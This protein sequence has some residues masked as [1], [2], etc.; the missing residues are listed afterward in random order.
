MKEGCGSGQ[1]WGWEIQR[2]GGFELERM[3]N[4]Y[5]YKKEVDERGMERMGTNIL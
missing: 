2:A 3:G 5:K 1:K 4:E